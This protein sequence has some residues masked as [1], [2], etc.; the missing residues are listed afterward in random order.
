MFQYF[1]CL[2][3]VLNYFQIECSEGGVKYELELSDGWYSV[4][5]SIDNEMVA[6]VYRKIFVGTK[7]LV[8]GA[9]LLNCDDGCD[10]LYVSVFNTM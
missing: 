7:L 3:T 9:E 8:C 5:A 6:L 2:I 1:K 4:T 10:P